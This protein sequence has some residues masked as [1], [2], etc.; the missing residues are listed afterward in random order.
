MKRKGAANIYLVA[1]IFYFKYLK[2]VV[3]ETPKTI[4]IS[5]VKVTP[6]ENV[7]AY[8]EE[9]DKISLEGQICICIQH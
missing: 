9:L 6:E 1:Y 8:F 4:V 5:C 3:K 2:L 7:R